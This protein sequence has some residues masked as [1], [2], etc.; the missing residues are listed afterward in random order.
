M[1]QLEEARNQFAEQQK[2]LIVEQ[3][4]QKSANIPVEATVEDVQRLTV[5][6]QRVDE[7]ERKLNQL[8]EKR[9]LN[10]DA[11]HVTVEER[12][13]EMDD[14]ISVPSEEMYT[15]HCKFREQI[16]RLAEVQMCHV[17]M[18]SYAGIQVRNSSIGPMCMRSL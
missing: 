12:G 3:Q 17:C 14:N 1:K 18:E 2:N 10:G 9:N 11:E 5:R 4:R 7:R 6:A 13:V 8:G 15:R 16:D